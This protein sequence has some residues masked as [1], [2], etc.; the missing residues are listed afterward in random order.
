M[1]DIVC[2]V[3]QDC[4]SPIEEP[5]IEIADVLSWHRWSCSDL[6]VLENEFVCDVTV[7]ATG[8]EAEERQKRKWGC[9]SIVS[10]IISSGVDRGPIELLQSYAES[11]L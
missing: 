5:I 3:M 11:P 8:S 6:G 2:F 7:N 9:I 4:V 10:G 1:F